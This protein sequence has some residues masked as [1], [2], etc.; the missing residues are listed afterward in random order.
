MGEGLYPFSKINLRSRVKAGMIV[1]VL[2][3]QHVDQVVNF[4]EDIQGWLVTFE[5]LNIIITLW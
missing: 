4:D 2:R 3:F 5:G 1:C